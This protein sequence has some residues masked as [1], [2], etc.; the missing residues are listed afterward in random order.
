MSESDHP[1]ILVWNIFLADG[2]W[3]DKIVHFAHYD[4]YSLSESKNVR[5]KPALFA[6]G[7]IPAFLIYRKNNIGFFFYTQKSRN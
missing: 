1:R 6:G 2:G 7:L 4:V 5:E 3:L